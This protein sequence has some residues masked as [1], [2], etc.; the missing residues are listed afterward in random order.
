M[1]GAFPTILFLSL[2]SLFGIALILGGLLMLGLGFV[3]VFMFASGALAPLIA[4]GLVC[5]AGGISFLIKI[6]RPA[7][8]DFRDG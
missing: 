3:S 1:R 2:A 7:L 5:A 4:V 6:V 8:R